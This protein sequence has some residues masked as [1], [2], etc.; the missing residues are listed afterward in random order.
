ML[1]ATPKWAIATK[2]LSNETFAEK[3]LCKV[4]TWEGGRPDLFVGCIPEHHAW[5]FYNAPG[6]P[7]LHAIHSSDPRDMGGDPSGLDIIGFQKSGLEIAER[8]FRVRSTTFVSL[9]YEPKP[10]WSWGS[11]QPF[12]IM[13]RPW[14]RKPTT[15]D[16][17][18]LA[19]ANIVGM[20]LYGEGQPH[21][22]LTEG[23]TAVMKS[24]SCYVSMVGIDGGFG[25][26]EHEA[27]AMGCPVIARRWGDMAVD[28]PKYPGFADSDEHLVALANACASD[29]KFARYL[30]EACIDYVAK[31]RTR[32]K[33]EDSVGMIL[34][35]FC[36][37]KSS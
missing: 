2:N 12:S 17:M 23:K 15:Q 18:K 27:M 31:F 21:G 3:E 4:P 28:F 32:Q 36:P 7:R 8:S 19:M 22:F 34:D 14:H 1:E 37:K 6:V 24:A 30:S 26:S 5:A 9:W 25:L 29:E 10:V 16:R 11:G 13:S 33:F 20:K 35:R